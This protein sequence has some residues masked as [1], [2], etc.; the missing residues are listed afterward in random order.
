MRCTVLIWKIDFEKQIDMKLIWKS[1][2]KENKEDGGE[3][4]YERSNTIKLLE[5]MAQSYYLKVSVRVHLKKAR[6]TS[7]AKVHH[8]KTS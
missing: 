5:M 2:R 4:N 1:S 6:K 3:E 7:C 8:P